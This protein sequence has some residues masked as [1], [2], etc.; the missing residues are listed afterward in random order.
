MYNTLIRFIRKGITFGNKSV[1][2]KY[3]YTNKYKADLEKASKIFYTVGLKNMFLSG[4]TTL[5]L[6]LVAISLKISRMQMFGSF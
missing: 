5:E 4:V 1:Q 3:L 6:A 2:S